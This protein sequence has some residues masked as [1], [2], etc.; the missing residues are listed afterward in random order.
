[1]KI[2]LLLNPGKFYGFSSN[3]L[4]F[5][6]GGVQKGSIDDVSGAYTAISDERL[7]TN[8]RSLGSVLGK[9]EQLEAKRYSF[10]GDKD[11]KDHIG[12]MAQDMQAEF[13]ELVSYRGAID[14][15]ESDLYTMNYSGLGVISLAAIQELN[16]LVKTQQKKIE[17]LEKE[18]QQLKNK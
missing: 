15:T 3:D 12:F 4:A 10:I 2:S 14:G 5:N 8:V 13:P 16:E 17:L 9:I 1:M 7:K 11:E 6:Y 18:V